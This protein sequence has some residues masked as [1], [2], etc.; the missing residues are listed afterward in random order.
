MN[1]K[2][3]DD[4]CGI[5][6]VDPAIEFF[7]MMAEEHHFP[8]KFK[9]H[10]LFRIDRNFRKKELQKVEENQGRIDPNYTWIYGND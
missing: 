9:R 4:L 10:I 2:L 3:Y 7:N 8:E 6:G 5:C 1:E